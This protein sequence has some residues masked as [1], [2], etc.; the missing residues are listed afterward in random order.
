MLC[1]Q[2]SDDKNTVN[3]EFW[4]TDA[5]EL[6]RIWDGVLVHGGLCTQSWDS[7]RTLAIDKAVPKS[8]PPCKRKPQGPPPVKLTTYSPAI[9]KRTP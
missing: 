7:T 9:L 4:A 1:K 3:I 6:C 5:G 2:S 8:F